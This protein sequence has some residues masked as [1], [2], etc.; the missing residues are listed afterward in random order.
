MRGFGS[1]ARSS[2][3]GARR[4][5]LLVLAVVG[6]ALAAAP[7]AFKMF[8]RG[9]QGAQMMDEFKPYMTAAR[10]DGFQRHIRAIDAAV[11]EADG[12][13]AAELEGPGAAAHRRFERRF[14][15][16]AQFR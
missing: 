9:P 11:R 14:P 4:T 16:F 8:D 10:L 6:L 12:P 1:G 13:V 15:G 7:V 5:A 3:S 2:A